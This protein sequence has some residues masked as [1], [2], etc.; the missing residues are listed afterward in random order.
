MVDKRFDKIVAKTGIPALLEHG[1]EECS[2]LAKAMQKLARKLRNENPTVATA[3]E[4]VEFVN[5]EAGDV[6]NVLEALAACQIISYQRID[7][8]RL[9]KQD[10]WEKRLD[11]MLGDI[12]E[13]DAQYVFDLLQNLK[14]MNK[15]AEE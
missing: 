10:R 14:E 13:Q 7:E 1:A 4:L 5:D 15:K 6:L 2:E 3:E 8:L 11:N 9:A 12:S